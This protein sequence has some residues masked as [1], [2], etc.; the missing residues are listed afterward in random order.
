MT[1][2][3]ARVYKK[4]PPRG[5]IIGKTGIEMVDDTTLKVP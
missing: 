4:S 1:S 5:L 2:N 3:S